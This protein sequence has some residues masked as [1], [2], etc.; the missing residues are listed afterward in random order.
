MSIKSKI[1]K[2]GICS[3]MMVVPLVQVSFPVFAVEEV[4]QNVVNIP[5]ANFRAELNRIFGQES[6]A[7][8]TESQMKK[9]T[10]LSLDEVTDLTGIEYA[11]NLITL[12]IKGT[13]V[14]TT[15][16]PTDMSMLT[17]L[18]I[19]EIT[20]SNIDNNIYSKLNT[21]PE[22]TQLS[23]EENKKITTLQG[24]NPPN[25]IRLTASYTGIVDFSGVEKIP[26]LTYFNGMQSL[27]NQW[28]VREYRE[29]AAPITIKSSE[30]TYDATK[31]TLF[32]P[33]TIFPRQYLTNFDGSK[34]GLDYKA[35]GNFLVR[36]MVGGFDDFFLDPV[37]YS[38]EGATLTGITQ[39]DF[40][41]MTYLLFIVYFANSDTIE[42]PA[43]L[44]NGDDNYLIDSKI[45]EVFFIEHS[46]NITAEAKV[47]YIAGENISPEQFL[48]D[49][50]AEANGATITSNLVDQVD[51]STPGT[52][53]VTLNAENTA[54]LK[55]EPI[56]VAVT[57]IKKTIITAQ[58]EVTYEMNESKTEAEFLT[59]I[60]AS[61]NDGSQ[62]TSDFATTVDFRKAGN[63]TVTLNAKNDKQKATPLTVKVAMNQKSSE[64]VVPDPAS[65]SVVPNP[66]P[67]KN[68][69]SSDEGK[70][71]LSINSSTPVVKRTL[72]KTGDTL[73]IAGALGGFLVLGLGVMIARKK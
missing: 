34:I 32:V 44:M 70:F 67:R 12:T 8:I 5:D 22:L 14:T 17:N 2:I 27:G 60:Q 56:Q 24:L 49:I 73:P 19:V 6:T 15:T 21:L 63:Y 23:I 30:L 38:S 51:F 50:K 72:P 36:G 54:G 42:K 62:I 40:D 26:K 52:Y 25:L 61:T 7:D 31:Q 71:A 55:G 13:G 9:V 28:G 47:S 48:A 58:P 37:I 45:G 64:P 18:K 43:N 53:K 16:F 59:D 66:I 1:L 3:T 46:V 11:T 4:N 20:Y 10:L 69:I 33:F 39:A 68:T 29:G 65:T 57:I 41:N 35:K